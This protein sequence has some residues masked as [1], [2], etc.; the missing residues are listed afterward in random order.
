MSEF[1]KVEMPKNFEDIYNSNLDGATREELVY[2][3][4]KNSNISE[5]RAKSLGYV[6]KDSFGSSDFFQPD[7]DEIIKSYRD[8]EKREDLIEKSGFVPKI[9]K[10]ELS[11][12][13]DQIDEE[14]SVLPE[15]VREQAYT[16]LE[17]A[18]KKGKKVSS[19]MIRGALNESMEFYESR[20]E[21]EDTVIN[22]IANGNEDRVLERA[23]PVILEL[24]EVLT[25]N[26]E[27]SQFELYKSIE[28]QEFGNKIRRGEIIEN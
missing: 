6:K 8:V 9:G 22:A 11:G 21:L 3:V 20:N 5:A 7:I 10:E 15:E 18:V 25:E 2:L 16:R 4:D 28:N 23:A 19:Y 12:L 24:S 13:K 14:Y 1:D 27:V 26:G 17:N